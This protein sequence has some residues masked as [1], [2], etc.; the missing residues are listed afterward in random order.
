MTY[1]AQ[2]WNAKF[3][4]RANVSFLSCLYLH[5]YL[6]LTYVEIMYLSWV[7]SIDIHILVWISREICWISLWNCRANVSFLSCLYLHIS[8]TQFNAN[9]L[10]I[11]PPIENSSQSQNWWIYLLY[12]KGKTVT[13]SNVSEKLS[14]PTN[15]KKSPILTH[16]GSPIDGSIWRI[17]MGQS[18]I[19]RYW[20]GIRWMN[21]RQIRKKEDE[22]ELW[23]L[24][25][26]NYDKNAESR[27]GLHNHPW[28]RRHCLLDNWQH[29]AI[30]NG[31]SC[32]W[33]YFPVTPR[34]NQFPPLPSQSAPPTTFTTTTTATTTTT[35]SKTTTSTTAIAAA[36]TNPIRIGTGRSHFAGII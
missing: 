33:R 16:I 4:S 8:L 36:T 21:R 6:I 14:C 1:V 30:I 31:K 29:W 35:S 19:L 7:V 10:H 25:P 22:G 24:L 34:A 26:G 9:S 2:N 27:I 3:V 11:A 18:C 13:I 17:A 5:M 20:I 23:R 15:Y 32:R 28:K 12:F